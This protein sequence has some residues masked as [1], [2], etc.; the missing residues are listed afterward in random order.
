[1]FFYGLCYEEHNFIATRFCLEKLV[2]ANNIWTNSIAFGKV[3]IG[4]LCTKKIGFGS[5]NNN[6]VSKH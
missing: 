6:D 5:D 2:T 3:S 1:M 4:H